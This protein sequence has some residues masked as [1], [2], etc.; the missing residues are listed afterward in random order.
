MASAPDVTIPTDIRASPGDPRVDSFKKNPAVVVMYWTED[1][2]VPQLADDPDLYGYNP[3][4]VAA[5][6]RRYDAWMDKLNDNLAKGRYVAVRG[7]ETDSSTV[8][9]P[10]SITAFK[11]ALSQSIEY[12]GT[13]HFI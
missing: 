3:E 7:W 13:F 12:Q 11:G 4:A 1:L 9:D 6:N 2:H 8:W 5:C 10:R